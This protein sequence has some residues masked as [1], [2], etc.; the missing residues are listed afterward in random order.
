MKQISSTTWK[1]I[2][3]DDWKDRLEIIVGDDKQLDFKPQIKIQRWD[4]EC[5]L[6]IRFID[7]L[8]LT[9]IISAFNNVITYSNNKI[10]LRFYN[11]DSNESSPKGGFEFEIILKEKPDINVL[12]FSLNDKNIEYYYQPP[13]NE[14]LNLSEYDYV[15]ETSAVKDNHVLVYRPPNVVGSYAVYYNKAGDYTKLGG[16]NYKTGKAFHI[17][18]PKIID[19]KGNWTWGTLHIENGILTIEIPQTFL[20][21]ATYPVTVDPTFGYETAGGSSV[22]VNNV[23]RGYS[24]SAPSSGT[25]DSETAYVNSL[26]CFAGDTLIRMADG[27]QKQAKDIK[28]GDDVL[29]YNFTTH[30]I[31]LNKVKSIRRFSPSELRYNYYIE[32]NNKLKVT[33]NQLLDKPNGTHVEALDIKVGDVFQG[34]HRVI[35]VF[36]V[37]RIFKRIPVYEFYT[38]KGGFF[39]DDFSD[40]LTVDYFRYAIYESH[41]LVGQTDQ[42]S[43]NTLASEN[44]ETASA[45]DTFSVDGGS[46]Y[47]I[48][49]WGGI[50]SGSDTVVYY[51]SGSTGS[52][53]YE[54]LTYDVNGYPS[55]IDKWALDNKKLSIYVSYTES[56]PIQGEASSIGDISLDTDQGYGNE[57]YIDSTNYGNEIR[58]KTIDE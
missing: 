31:G 13:L 25:V 45:V 2:Q 11:I 30:S 26:Q 35:K 47:W 12:E 57:L 14:E 49:V 16:K 1:F 6:S 42:V 15:N 24:A 29:Y 20:D 44:W 17:Y 58:F 50:H 43:K 32:I 28:V 38:S 34:Y 51:D 48:T 10:D 33:P 41:D 23:V 56:Q 52:A 19:S 21:N 9:S 36:S 8:N 3:S 55:T 40:V 22:S 7:K 39:I 37:K 4:N 53:V 27:S 46:S 5:N 54:S 18:R